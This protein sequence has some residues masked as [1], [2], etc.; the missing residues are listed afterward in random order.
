MDT[1]P[2]A[3]Q[4]PLFTDSDPECKFFCSEE[5]LTPESSPEPKRKKRFRMQGKKYLI[6]FPQCSVK[7]EEVAKK[8]EEKFKN[9]KGYIVCEEVHQ[10]GTPHL[11]AFVHFEE[12]QVFNSPD[13]FDFLTGKHGNYKVANSVRGSVNY[14][15]KAGKYIV[16]GID[17]ESIQKKRAPKSETVAKMLMD[18]KSL[19]E[20][21]DEDPGY[22]MLN[23]RKIEDYQ[24]WIE[25]N[26]AKKSKLTWVP[27]SLDGLTDTNKQIAEW[28]CSNV[29]QKRKFK[30]PQLF[31]YGPRN[32]GKTSLIEWLEQYLSVYHIPMG[33]EF[34]DLYS[35]DYDLVVMNEFKGQKTIQWMNS[36]LQG[37]PMNIRKK[38][39][40]YMKRA[41]LPAIILS[42]YSLS[43]CY[44]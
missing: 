37:G 34:Y 43:E 1:F 16:K 23:K 30:C 7:K 2:T 15:T 31:I 3:E 35:D 20:I 29:R 11:H 28:I 14:V 8:L 18:G 13:C 41:N 10:D 33:E 27:P 22:V 40:Q 24:S 4:V 5:E 42:N 32:L 9:M 38:G 6:T 25:C 19:E 17:I 44:P 36:F 26:K 39:S 12:R 21:N